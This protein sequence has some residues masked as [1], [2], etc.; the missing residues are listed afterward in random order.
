MH[1][2][3]WVE[4]VLAAH[5]RRRRKPDCIGDS[6]LF[7]VTSSMVTARIFRKDPPRITASRNQLVLSLL[8]RIR[9]R[10]VAIIN[11]KR[12]SH[13]CEP[14]SRILTNHSCARH[15]RE[16]S[17]EEVDKSWWRTNWRSEQQSWRSLLKNLIRFLPLRTTVLETRSADRRCTSMNEMK[18]SWRRSNGGGEN[19]VALVAHCCSLL[20]VSWRPHIFIGKTRLELQRLVT[21]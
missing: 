15:A 7:V 2:D 21:D 19:L 1:V 17:V 12:K 3:E 5:Q 10:L 16:W 8:K 9:H 20:L 13:A 11:N 6:W 14:L 4:V 18:L